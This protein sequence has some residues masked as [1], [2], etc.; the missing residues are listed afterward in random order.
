MKHITS[1]TNPLIQQLCKLHEK[2]YR[3][4][5][6]LFVF[7]GKKLLAEAKDSGVELVHVLAVEDM[8]PFCAEILGSKSDILIE[9]GQSVY[10]KLTLENSPEGVFVVARPLDKSKKIATIYDNKSSLETEC[11]TKLLL[12]SIRDTGNLG[13]IVRSAVAFGVDEVILTP[14]C[15]EVYNPKTIRASMGAVFRADI[16]IVSCEK[17]AVTALRDD[18]YSVYAT[19]LSDTSLSLGQVELPERCCFVIGNEANGLDGE[20]IAACSETLTIPM[21]CGVESLNAAMAATAILWESFR[22]RKDE[23]N[24]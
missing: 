23:R 11:N 13:T 20:L 14:D 3:A 19:A 21:A 22:S 24:V 10:D 5:E 15:A 6:S 9:V 8:L 18:G 4:Q 16:T 17:Q 7:E 12:S 2:K 1:R